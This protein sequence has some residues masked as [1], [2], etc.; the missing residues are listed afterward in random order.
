MI[1]NMEEEKTINAPATP[2]R[3]RYKE[4]FSKRHSDIDFDNEEMKEDRYAALNDDADL[5]DE[6]ESS[7]KALS[8][9]LDKNRWIGAMLMDLKD[10]PD[11]DPITWMAQNGIDINEAMEDEEYKQKI[12]DLIADH[13]K[14]QIE[15]EEAAKQRDDNLKK[16]ADALSALGLSNEENMKL[17]THMFTNVIEPALK[18]EISTETWQMLQKALNHDNDVAVAEEQGAMR[19]RNEKI[20][21]NLRKPT[22]EPMPPSLSQTAQ[23]HVAPAK[24][25]TAASDFFEGLS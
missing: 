20:A 13:Q 21:N 24:K 8:D 10:D 3:D 5:L 25:K 17:W 12:A 19:A 18:G 9:V 7:G 22:A 4:R 15:G 23:G 16:S 14:K 2:N 6:Y 11:L 1:F